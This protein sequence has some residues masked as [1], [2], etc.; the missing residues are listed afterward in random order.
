MTAKQRSTAI[1]NNDAIVCAAEWGGPRPTKRDIPQPWGRS[2]R[3]ADQ[4]GRL[5]EAM[6]QSCHVG[7]SLGRRGGGPGGRGWAGRKATEL[8]KSAGKKD[9]DL[10]QNSVGV[11]GTGKEASWGP[12]GSAVRFGVP[13]QPDCMQLLAGAA[14]EP[15]V[16]KAAPASRPAP[17]S[18]LFMYVALLAPHARQGNHEPHLIPSCPIMA[19]AGHST[20]PAVSDPSPQPR[21]STVLTIVHPISLRPIF[22]EKL[23]GLSA[24]RPA[25]AR[26]PARQQTCRRTFADYLRPPN[27]QPTCRVHVDNPSGSG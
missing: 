24:R 20:S 4:R 9:Q 23:T 25:A 18:P 8:T 2:P 7:S 27:I 26:L 1:L 17:V 6:R 12:L 10:V 14:G 19:L 22:S 5:T 21:V 3:P 16:G 15:E 11:S 13:R